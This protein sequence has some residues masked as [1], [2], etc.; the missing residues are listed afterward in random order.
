[1]QK[2][3]RELEQNLAKISHSKWIFLEDFYKALTAKVGES[4]EVTL[5]KKGKNWTY[6]FPL[7]EK[8]EKKFIEFI[9]LDRFNKLGL[10]D[11]GRSQDKICIRL[12]EFGSHF[13]SFS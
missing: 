8:N 13:L 9:L 5:E 7:Y 4:K 10:I 6:Q 3:L 1:M 11:T 12:S 2:S